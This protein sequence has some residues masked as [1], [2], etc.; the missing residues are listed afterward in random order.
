MAEFTVS[1]TAEGFQVTEY[2]L[3]PLVITREEDGRYSTDF[4]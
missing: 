3:Q 1:L 2:S 4:E